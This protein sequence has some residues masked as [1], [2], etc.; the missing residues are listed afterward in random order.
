MSGDDFYD[1]RSRGEIIA[2]VAGPAPHPDAPEQANTQRPVSVADMSTH[3]VL[4]KI[5]QE[6]RAI[7]IHLA[8]MTD[9]G[10]EDVRRDAH[11]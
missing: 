10:V 1:K 11:G 3:L 7:H 6:L 2:P 4:E 5:F 8:T 9:N